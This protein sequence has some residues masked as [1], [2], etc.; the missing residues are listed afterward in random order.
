MAGV[1]R[2]FFSSSSS[3][4][5]VDQKVGNDDSAPFGTTPES[6]SLP[7]CTACYLRR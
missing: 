4:L 3:E 5:Q 7:Y 2:A 6:I 1:P